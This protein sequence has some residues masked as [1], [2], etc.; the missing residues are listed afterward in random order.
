M[1]ASHAVAQVTC[2]SLRHLYLRP[3]DTESSFARPRPGKYYAE[4]RCLLKQAN[5]F[6]DGCVVAYPNMQHEIQCACAHAAREEAGKAP[7]SEH[8]VLSDN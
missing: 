8:V 2:A 3:R 4:L 6:S 7:F 5:R 1:H